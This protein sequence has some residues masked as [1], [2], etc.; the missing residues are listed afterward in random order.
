MWV[1]W[2]FR[3]GNELTRALEGKSRIPNTKLQKNTNLQIPMTA[4]QLRLERE[5]R[6]PRDLWGQRQ[7]TG[8][9]QDASRESEL[10][11]H[12]ASDLDCGGPPPLSV[13][14]SGRVTGLRPVGFPHQRKRKNPC[15]SVVKTF[16]PLQETN[17]FA[18]IRFA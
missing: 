11:A 6:A 10:T 4:T 18:I 5:Y 2:K 12:R 7:R 17:W 14:R 3:R 16:A 9:L 13:L 8:A 1:W 15:R